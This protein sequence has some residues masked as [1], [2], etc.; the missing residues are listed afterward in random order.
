MIITILCCTVLAGVCAIRITHTVKIIMS[1][2]KASKES[3]D[4][5]G[6]E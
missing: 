4:G 3:R 1:Y 6:S 5:R 2:C